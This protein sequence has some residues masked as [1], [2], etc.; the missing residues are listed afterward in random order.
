VDIGLW[1]FCGFGQ[2]AHRL[3]LH[4]GSKNVTI[5]TA[6]DS[7]KEIIFILSQGA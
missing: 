1:I 5:D 7:F 2:H 4:G 3:T 6:C